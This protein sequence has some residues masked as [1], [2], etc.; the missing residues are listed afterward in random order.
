MGLLRAERTDVEAVAR[1]RMAERRIVDLGIVGE[2]DESRIVVDAERRQRH[3]R[4][5]GDHLH[6]GEAFDR[7]KCGARI[8]DGDVI[9]EQLGDRR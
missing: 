7:R 2:R 6:V 5:F 4:P 1:E 3:V 9:T 8:D